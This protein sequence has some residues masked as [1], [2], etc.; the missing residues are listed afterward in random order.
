MEVSAIPSTSQEDSHFVEKTSVL[1][2]PDQPDVSP[3]CVNCAHLLTENRKLSRDVKTL[4]EIMKRRQKEV[5]KYQRKSK[6]KVT[7][8]FSSISDALSW[9]VGQF[10][11]FLGNYNG[12]CSFIFLVNNLES[13]IKKLKTAVKSPEKSKGVE[14]AIATDSDEN[15]DEEDYEMEEEYSEE[16]SSSHASQYETE[17]ETSETE[18]SIDL[19]M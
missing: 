10:D 3:A 14:E 5:K 16:E 6:N 18:E 9:K 13:R 15:D 12:I 1:E 7:F 19:D 4:R 17:T 11:T 2:T 8:G